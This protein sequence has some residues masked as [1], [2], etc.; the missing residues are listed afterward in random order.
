VN[1]I[2]EKTC[3]SP[4]SAVNDSRNASSR[5][6]AMNFWNPPF[7]SVIWRLISWASSLVP[8]KS[9]EKSTIRFTY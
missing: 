1:N 5:W 7:S 3:S 8:T 9:L 4:L 2:A 6:E